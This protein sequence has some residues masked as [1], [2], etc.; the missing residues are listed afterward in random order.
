MTNYNPSLELAR[1][2]T[3]F[4]DI[5][6]QIGN[7]MYDQHGRALVEIQARTNSYDAPTHRIFE[8]N[9][10]KPRYLVGP[11]APDNRANDLLSE[12][13][14]IA[15]RTGNE[16][17]ADILYGHMTEITAEELNTAMEAHAE[18][19]KIRQAVPEFPADLAS[20]LNNFTQVEQ[21]K[22]KKM[23][24]EMNIK[25]ALIMGAKL[26][27]GKILLD[28]L[29]T[30][31]LAAVPE[32][33]KDQLDN[34][35]VRHIL[36]FLAGAGIMHGGEYLKEKWEP[37]GHLQEVGFMAASVETQQ[38]IDAVIQTIVPFLTQVAKNFMSNP[39][40]AELAQ[41]PAGTAEMIDE[42]MVGDLVNGALKN[43]R[44]S[45]INK[46]DIVE[47]KVIDAAYARG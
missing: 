2:Q 41:L 8:L 10:P 37:L 22:E 42:N 26:A 11:F 43:A 4:D 28:A 32:Q 27:E 19:E 15:T 1:L 24:Q 36:R 35:A 21:P 5:R 46:T 13:H 30:A 17:W 38:S 29:E 47:T 33:Y 7:F 45:K 6:A 14:G 25:N 39:K 9:G 40:V 31:V 34:D 18:L 3:A 16:A 20:D 44:E 23:T 12:L